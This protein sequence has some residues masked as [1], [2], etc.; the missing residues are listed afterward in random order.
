ME[1][2][3]LFHKHKLPA[4]HG[5]APYRISTASQEFVIFTLS[6]PHLCRF[7]LFLF[8]AL[9]MQLKLKISLYCCLLLGLL[10]CWVEQL[11]CMQCFWPKH[12]IPCLRAT[13]TLQNIFRKRVTWAQFLC[14]ALPQNK[15]PPHAQLAV[16]MCLHTRHQLKP[17]QV[18][19]SSCVPTK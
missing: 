1:P 19:A 5:Y 13:Q 2:L 12:N 3:P 8:L 10:S 4:S 16:T 9:P 17:Q 7:G 15:L 11:L 6:P 14:I 18:C